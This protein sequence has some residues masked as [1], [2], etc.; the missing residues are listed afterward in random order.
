MDQ[1]KIFF[2]QIVCLDQL[3][4]KLAKLI[5]YRME[6]F[7]FF[8]T[9]F[10]IHHHT[11]YDRSLIR[12]G[13]FNQAADAVS[14]RSRC[15]YLP[16]NSA[17]DPMSIRCNWEERKHQVLGTRDICCVIPTDKHQ[18]WES[19]AVFTWVKRQITPRGKTK[20]SKNDSNLQQ[21]LLFFFCCF[22]NAFLCSLHSC[23]LLAFYGEK[24]SPRLFYNIRRH[25]LKRKLLNEEIL[26]LALLL[27]NFFSSLEIC[28]SFPNAQKK[29]KLL[30]KT[31]LFHIL[32]ARS[33]VCSRKGNKL[34]VKSVLMSF[35]GHLRCE[36]TL[37]EFE[38]KKTWS[39]N[40]ATRE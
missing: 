36:L 4:I 34:R 9:S 7:R 16:F 29:R 3:V 31:K 30:I 27:L 14:T 12:S 38:K 37:N 19:R 1:K 6:C 15:K 10:M 13:D 20:Q 39:W 17:H 5:D 2:H 8:S 23:L 32:R 22:L 33:I 24:F 28:F 40:C 25:E 26:V 11:I 18:I 21:S 35:S